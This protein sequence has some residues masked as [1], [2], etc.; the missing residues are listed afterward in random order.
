ML[1]LIG[2]LAML[3]VKGM[4][5][6]L[7]LL[8]ELLLLAKSMISLALFAGKSLNTITRPPEKIVIVA[9]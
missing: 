6:K 7:L 1:D 5:L 2:L 3:E 8:C 9:V 4:G